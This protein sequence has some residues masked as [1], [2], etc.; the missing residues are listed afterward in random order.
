MQPLPR[1]GFVWHELMTS[2]PDRAESF[3]AE[4]VGLEAT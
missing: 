2:N 3:Y 4:V 1:K